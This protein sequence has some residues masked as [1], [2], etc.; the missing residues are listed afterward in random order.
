VLAPAARAERHAGPVDRRAVDPRVRLAGADAIA[1]ATP[2]AAA[3][4][5]LTEFFS[6]FRDLN[7]G[8]SVELDRLV[9]Q[10]LQIVRGGDP[11]QRWV[12]TLATIAGG[13][14][15]D[16]SQDSLLTFR[17]CGNTLPRVN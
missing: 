16:N 5:N 9:N 6:R 7:I 14:M 3:V 15:F 1:A 10:A 4:T 2:C 13:Q 17:L 8:S 11:A 12:T